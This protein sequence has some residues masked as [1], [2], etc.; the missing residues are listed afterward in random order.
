MFLRE[1]KLKAGNRI[2]KYQ[3]KLVEY[4]DLKNTPHTRKI[5]TPP[6]PKRRKKEQE[7]TKN[8]GFVLAGV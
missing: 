1:C 5:F 6:T 8:R 4:I 3:L 2:L 7:R